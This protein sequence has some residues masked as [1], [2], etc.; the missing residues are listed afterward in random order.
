[1]ENLPPSSELNSYLGRAVDISEKG[2]DSLQLAIEI[3]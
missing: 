3:E 2:C 1:M